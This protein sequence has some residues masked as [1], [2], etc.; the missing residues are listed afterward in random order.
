MILPVV[1]I[2]WETHI[3][4]I[5]RRVCYIEFWLRPKLMVQEPNAFELNL[6]K[7]SFEHKYCFILNGRIMYILILECFVRPLLGKNQFDKY[8][9]EQ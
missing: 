1:K 3:L 6:N 4:S 8:F 7:Y 9:L 2:R 5:A